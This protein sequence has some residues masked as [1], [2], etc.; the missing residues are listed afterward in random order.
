[1]SDCLPCAPIPHRI[2]RWRHL[3]RVVRRVV[4][5]IHHHSPGV[6]GACCGGAAWLG[7]ILPMAHPGPVVAPAG[8]PVVESPAAAWPDVLPG[9]GGLI[10]PG[11]YGPGSIGPLPP[12]YVAP[13]QVAEWLP[14]SSDITVPTGSSGVP[15]E[16][17]DTPEPPALAVVALGLVAAAVGQALRARKAPRRV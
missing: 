7:S 6:F 10:A 14:E 17:V 3:H 16:Q 15:V 1:M 11:G 13:Q 8:P 5:H 12:D 2:H 9:Y 4:H